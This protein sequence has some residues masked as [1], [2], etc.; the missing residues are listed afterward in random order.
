[1]KYCK[2]CGLSLKGSF[3][4]VTVDKMTKNSTLCNEPSKTNNNKY[5]LLCHQGDLR[6]MWQDPFVAA[7]AKL[8]FLE[9]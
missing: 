5:C 2:L 7:S 4:Q 1:M 6:K 8:K 3:S 9:V